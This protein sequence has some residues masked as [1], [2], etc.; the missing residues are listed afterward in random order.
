MSTVMTP[1]EGYTWDD[2]DVQVY[3]LIFDNYYEAARYAHENIGENPRI[4]KGKV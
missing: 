3:R 2:A 1:R 4:F